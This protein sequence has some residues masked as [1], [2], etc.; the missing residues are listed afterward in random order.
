MY[1]KGVSIWDGFGTFKFS[2]GVGTKYNGK[3][4]TIYQ[5]HKDGSITTTSAVVTGGKVDVSVMDMGTFYVVL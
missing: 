1:R 3:T 5:I 4:A 2:V